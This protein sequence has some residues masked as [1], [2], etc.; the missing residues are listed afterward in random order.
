MGNKTSTGS[1]DRSAIPEYDKAL[2]NGDIEK[3]KQILSSGRLGI[4]MYIVLRRDSYGKFYYSKE[5]LFDGTESYMKKMYGP[6]LLLFIFRDMKEYLKRGEELKVL[7][8]IDWLLAHGASADG[9]FHRNYDTPE[10][11]SIGLAISN[12]AS[13]AIVRKLLQFGAFSAVFGNERRANTIFKELFSKGLTEN[14]ILLMTVF[15]D[16]AHRSFLREELLT[17]LSTGRTGTRVFTP[18]EL[19]LFADAVSV[20]TPDFTRRNLLEIIDRRNGT[21]LAISPESYELI[22]EKLNPTWHRRKHMVATWLATRGYNAR[23][24][25]PVLESTTPKP[26]NSAGGR[27]VTRHRKAPRRRSTRRVKQSH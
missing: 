5:D 11:E 8:F 7:D 22:Q 26:A 16:I 21:P 10:E 23:A 27:R 14:A 18:E 15:N 3:A 12:D 1:Y 25:I 24:P 4:N 20:L 19:Q 17:R 13:P 2:S 9:I 6:P